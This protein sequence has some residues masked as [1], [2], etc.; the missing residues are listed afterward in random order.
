MTAETQTAVVTTVSL[1]IST[2]GVMVTAWIGFKIRE[3]EH[4]TNSIKDA[5]VLKTAE[6]SHAKGK[7]EGKAEEKEEERKRRT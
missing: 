7:A 4:N 6:S 2:A 3:L 5:L 1:F